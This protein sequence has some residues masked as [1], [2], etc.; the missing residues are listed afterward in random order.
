MKPDWILA[1]LSRGPKH[2]YMNVLSRGPKHVYMNVLSR[3]PKHVYMN[4]LSR[5][6][7]H[8]YMNVLSRGPKHVYIKMLPRGPKIHINDRVFIMQIVFSFFQNGGGQ[9]VFFLEMLPKVHV[10]IIYQIFKPLGSPMYQVSTWSRYGPCFKDCAAPDAVSIQ[11]RTRVVHTPATGGRSCPSHLMEVR[12]C[13]WEDVLCPTF[14]WEAGDWGP[15]G[16]RGVHC[17]ADGNYILLC[18][19]FAH[20]V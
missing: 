5:G 18:L 14:Y 12:P 1:C 16:R 15:N 3:G 20:L 6:P 10:C 13:R 2:V 11:V 4:V 8:V 9:N 19:Y 7:K 17:L